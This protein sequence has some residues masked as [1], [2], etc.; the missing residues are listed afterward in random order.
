MI[1]SNLCTSRLNV[2]SNVYRELLDNQE[3]KNVC[4]VNKA[5][6]N[7]KKKCEVCQYFMIKFLV[8]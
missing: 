8:I 7:I 3:V 6:F 2:V 4:D 5:T 1:G